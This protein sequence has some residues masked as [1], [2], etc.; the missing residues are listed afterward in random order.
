MKPDGENSPREATSCGLAPAVPLRRVGRLRFSP[1]RWRFGSLGARSFSGTQ[2]KSPRELR[3]RVG[4]FELTAL[5]QPGSTRLSISFHI[6]P[7]KT[8]G[9]ASLLSRD[10]QSSRAIRS[11]GFRRRSCCRSSGIRLRAGLCSLRPRRNRAATSH[12][13]VQQIGQLDLHRLLLAQPLP[14][15]RTI[16][17]GTN[18]TMIEVQMADMVVFFHHR[19][20]LN[21]E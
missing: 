13:R 6:C 9:R 2:R 18:P 5:A 1:R 17:I 19:C 12:S 21:G 10:A 8:L 16:V 14:A 4:S 11:Q 15:D 7:A 3:G 20:G